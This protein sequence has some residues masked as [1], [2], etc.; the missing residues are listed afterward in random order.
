[1][2]KYSFTDHKGRK[3]T[4]ANMVKVFAAPDKNPELKGAECMVMSASINGV[5]ML[6]VEK[7][8]KGVNAKRIVY[9]KAENLEFLRNRP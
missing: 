1:M 8:P 6:S 5:V 7:L 9:V 3:V 2:S 4:T